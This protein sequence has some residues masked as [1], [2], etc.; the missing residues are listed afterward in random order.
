MTPQT[1]IRVIVSDDQTITVDHDRI[2]RVAVRTVRHHNAR[3]EISITLLDEDRMAELHL[4]YMNEPGPTDVLSFPVDGL[5]ESS[6]D[7]PGEGFEAGPPVLIGEVVI[8]P[9]VAAGARADL[10]LE[11]DLLVAHGVLH[12]LGHDHEDEPGAE[13]MR[14]MEKR[15]TGRSGARAR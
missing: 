3:G 12:L 13:R 14:A 1:D 11:L 7:P 15:I 2:V 4:Q 10:L 5:S 8:C 6:A 9:A